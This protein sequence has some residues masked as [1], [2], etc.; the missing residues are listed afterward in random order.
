MPGL[1]VLFGWISTEASER[2]HLLS[3]GIKLGKYDRGG[4]CYLDCIVPEE[5]LEG[6]RE[7]AQAFPPRA[8]FLLE[9]LE[10]QPAC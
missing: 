1:T 4:G 2:R 3:L 9:E 5:A 7:M 10:E 6:L 8:L